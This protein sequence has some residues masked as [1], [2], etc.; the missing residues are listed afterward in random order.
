M[1]LMIRPYDFK[2]KKKHFHVR[3]QCFQPIRSYQN[4]LKSLHAN[5]IFTGH[6]YHAKQQEINILCV[7]P[8]RSQRDR[9]V[10]DKIILSMSFAIEVNDKGDD[11]DDQYD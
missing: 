3:P 9:S 4:K 10:R 7:H 5:T 11:N 2:R 6:S 1:L 8:F